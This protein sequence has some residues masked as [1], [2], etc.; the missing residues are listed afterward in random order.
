MNTNKQ[1]G[2]TLIE[3]MIVVAI[4]GLL[5]A[6]AVPQYTDYT[7]RTI[8]TGAVN[9]S[10]NWKTSVSMCI[11]DQGT[12]AASCGA[13]SVNGIPANAAAG[14]VTYVESVTTT[15]SGVITVT[16]EA[17]NSDGDLLV[18]VLTPNMAGSTVAWAMT[19]SGCDTPGRS[20]NC[21]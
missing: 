15:G 7:Q 21:E 14:E 11:Q 16:T 6:I 13:P 3:L 1:A 2:F 19:G 20:I 18:V 8:V 4:I 10:L 12:I 17:V 9:G 5:A